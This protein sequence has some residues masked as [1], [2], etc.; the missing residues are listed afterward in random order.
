MLCVFPR[1]VNKEQ[2]RLLLVSKYT[3]SL[4][5]KRYES[6]LINLSKRVF[7]KIVVW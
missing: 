5:P 4:V 6:I 1:L 3:K 2:S 7:T